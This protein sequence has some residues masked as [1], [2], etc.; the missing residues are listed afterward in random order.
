M[1]EYAVVT[2]STNE[3]QLLANVLSPTKLYHFLQ[4][5]FLTS[6]VVFRSDLEATSILLGPLVHLSVWS[7]K[8]L[9]G[10]T[11]EVS[12]QTT[13]DILVLLGQL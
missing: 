13:L 3:E 5:S 7:D 11:V 2:H 12:A 1:F 9:A 4:D 10:L 6:C 8:L